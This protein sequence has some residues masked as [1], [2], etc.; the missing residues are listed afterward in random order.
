MIFTTIFALSLAMFTDAMTREW[1]LGD[2]RWTDEE[3]ILSITGFLVS[4]VSVA[5]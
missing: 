1:P 4:S 2:H 5:V 3:A